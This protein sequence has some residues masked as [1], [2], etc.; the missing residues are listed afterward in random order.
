VGNNKVAHI[1]KAFATLDGLISIFIILLLDIE[2]T[3]KIIAIA[4]IVVTHF[5]IYA[6]GEVIDLLQ[7][8]KDKTGTMPNATPSVKEA[9]KELPN[10]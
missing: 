1:L 7:D 8:I 6:F 5:M 10:I 2:V 3:L 4:S 9:E